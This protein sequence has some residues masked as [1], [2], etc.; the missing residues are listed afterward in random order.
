MVMTTLYTCL[1]SP[2][3][4]QDIRLDCKGRHPTTGTCESST[5]YSKCQV[6]RSIPSPVSPTSNTYRTSKKCGFLCP[7]TLIHSTF[8]MKLTWTRFTYCV[9]GSSP[10]LSFA[11]SWSFNIEDFLHNFR[12]PYQIFRPLWEADSGKFKLQLPIVHFSKIANIPWM[13]IH[14]VIALI[15]FVSVK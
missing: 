8:F 1:W 11:R 7:A 10:L 14:F 12:V 2:F 5:S 3:W 15:G 13:P 4:F 9:F 6:N